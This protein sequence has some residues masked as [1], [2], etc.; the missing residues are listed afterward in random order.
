[1]APDARTHPLLRWRR[2]R[3]PRRRPRR[4]GRATLTGGEDPDTLV[5]KGG[6]AA[7][8][9]VL[10]AARPLG[11]ALYGLVA[12]G[13]PI[14]TPEQRAA[15]RTRLEEAARSITDRALA[16]E[17]RRALLDRFFAATR[18]G[19]GGPRPTLRAPRPDI[20][21]A[22]TRAAQSAALLAITLRHPWLLA[23]IEESLGALDLVPESAAQLRDRL[24]AWLAEGHALDSQGLMDHLAQTGAG[25]FAASLL[26]DPTLPRE[27]QPDAQPRE[28]LDGWWHF[29][30]LL[31]GEAEL[32]ADAETVAGAWAEATDTVEQTRLQRRLVRIQGAIGALRRGEVEEEGVAAA[33]S[34]PG[35]DA[36]I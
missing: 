27:A 13:R 32:A 18:P 35:E 34:A 12:E 14:A 23:E 5:R 11:E 16:A 36:P 15:L 28:A 10:D 26:R 17:Y 24:L 20:S 19:R 8:Q 1:V 7:F 4:R 25:A 9:S 29:Y 30:A 21:E 6:A 3:R 31:R 2:R 22:R 33:A